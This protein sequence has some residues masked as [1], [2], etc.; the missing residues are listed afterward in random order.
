MLHAPVYSR[1]RWPVRRNREEPACALLLF[2][3]GETWE[4]GR[5]CVSTIDQDGNH[6][7]LTL[8]SLDINKDMDPGKGGGSRRKQCSFPAVLCPCLTCIPFS[9]LSHD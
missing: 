2:C 9:L 6:P 3:M 5:F 7:G 8:L 1:T 4:D